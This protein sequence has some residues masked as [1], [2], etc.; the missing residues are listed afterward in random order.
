[1]RSAAK[2]VVLTE[3]VSQLVLVAETAA[4]EVLLTEM[5]GCFTGQVSFTLTVLNSDTGRMVNWHH[6]AVP[7]AESGG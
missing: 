7:E 3:R 6:D 4:D 5:M 1:M 2:R